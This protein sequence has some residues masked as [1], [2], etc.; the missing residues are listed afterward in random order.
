MQKEDRMEATLEGNGLKEFID[1]NIPKQKHQ[2]SK[3]ILI[4]EARGKGE[5]D[6]P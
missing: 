6:N 3:S 1:Q 4:E 5:V 2:R